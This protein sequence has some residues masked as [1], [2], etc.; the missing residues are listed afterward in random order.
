M[1]LHTLSPGLLLAQGI[2]GET[3]SCVPAPREDE[4]GP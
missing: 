2:Q 1:Q 3:A 4:K